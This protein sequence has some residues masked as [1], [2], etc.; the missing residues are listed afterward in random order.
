LVQLG[1][2]DAAHPAARKRLNA[3]IRNWN[4]IETGMIRPG[5]AFR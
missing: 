2:L 3:P 1:L 4:G 5:A